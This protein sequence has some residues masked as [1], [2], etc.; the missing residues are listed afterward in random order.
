MRVVEQVATREARGDGQETPWR[1]GPWGAYT[2]YRMAGDDLAPTVPAG[3]I[4]GVD[5]ARVARD[6]DVVV[7]LQRRRGPLVGRLRVVDGQRELDLGGW[8]WEL[9][10]GDPLGVVALVLW[11]I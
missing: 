8:T 2:Y 5:P 4:V 6:G 11:E 1:P 9:D 10:P 3:A 7:R